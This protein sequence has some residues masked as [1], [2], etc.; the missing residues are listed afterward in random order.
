MPTFN[1]S[2]AAP[3]NFGVAAPPDDGGNQ[4]IFSRPDEELDVSRDRGEE[5]PDL[6]YN[7]TQ[8]RRPLRGAAWIAVIFLL[9]L[10]A[11]PLLWNYAERGG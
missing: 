5:S 4:G 3:Q 9:L 2:S 11:I 6:Q 8:R 1:T 7:A 10:F